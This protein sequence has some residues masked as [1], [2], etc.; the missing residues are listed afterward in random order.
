M[1]HV[2]SS[3]RVLSPILEPSSIARGSCSET[4]QQKNEGRGRS[5]ALLRDLVEILPRLETTPMPLFLADIHLHRANP[6]FR[7][8]I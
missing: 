8:A 3:V 6:F 5:S 4:C 7:E 1:S 2:A